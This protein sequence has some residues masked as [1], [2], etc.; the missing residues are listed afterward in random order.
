[1]MNALSFCPITPDDYEIVE[2]MVIDFYREGGDDAET[3]FM[4][5]SKVRKT[6]AQTLTHPDHLKIIVFRNEMKVVGYAIL[7]AFWSNE[8][9]G[10]VGIVDEL[11]VIPAYR[12]RGIG[13]RFIRQLIEAKDYVALQLEVFHD[14]ERAF[15]LY[16]RLGFGII[17]RKFMHKPLH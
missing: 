17:D 1:M 7:S 9:G 5:D 4:T 16:K 2:R 15:E 10:L 8:Y 13:S 12:G 6:I 14:N 11:Y 3:P